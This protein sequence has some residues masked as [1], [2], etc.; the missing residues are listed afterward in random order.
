MVVDCVEMMMIG[1]VEVVW[2]CTGVLVDV[3]TVI[4]GRD[5]TV[6]L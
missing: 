5:E 6:V 1:V 3:T 2:L 4:V